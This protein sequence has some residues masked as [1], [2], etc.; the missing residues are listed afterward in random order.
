MGYVL[1]PKID[2][3]RKRTCLGPVNGVLFSKTESSKFIT[4]Q[5]VVLNMLI[6]CKAISE[7]VASRW[8]TFRNQK[9]IENPKHRV[10]DGVN[11]IVLNKSVSNK[12]ITMQNVHFST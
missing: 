9:S 3:K 10:Q 1:E 11:E 2:R 4:V 8:A 6:S 12:F 5:N 7:F